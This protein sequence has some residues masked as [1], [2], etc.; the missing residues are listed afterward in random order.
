[1]QKVCEA[2]VCTKITPHD[3]RR[4]YLR[5]AEAC[6]L[7]VSRI[8][9]LVHHAT[10]NDITANYVGYGFIDDAGDDAQRVEDFLMGV[11]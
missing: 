3:L 1:M 7:P 11:R 8:K 10:G 2:A 9:A 4:T 5:A 6:G